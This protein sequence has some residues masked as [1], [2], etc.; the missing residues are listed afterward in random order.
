[1]IKTGIERI[2]AIP[3]LGI[4]VPQHRSQCMNMGRNWIFQANTNAGKE[5]IKK[6]ILRIIWL[7]HIKKERNT[8]K[9]VNPKTDEKIILNLFGLKNSFNL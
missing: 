2:C 6:R 4:H 8:A 3:E 1:M 5:R 9:V 7:S